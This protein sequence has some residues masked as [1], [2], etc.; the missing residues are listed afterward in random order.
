MQPL[1]IAGLDPAAGS[2]R[3]NED[4]QLQPKPAESAAVEPAEFEA[5]EPAKFEAAEPAESAAAEPGEP[6]FELLMLDCSKVFAND[7]IPGDPP[8]CA[9]TFVPL[10]ASSSA[11]QISECCYVAVTACPSYT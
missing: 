7:D 6:P 9:A 4:C 5:A 3:S 8:G 10:L 1:L 11:A 2:A